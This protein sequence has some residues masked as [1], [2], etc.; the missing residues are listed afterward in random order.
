MK[1]DLQKFAKDTTLKMDVAFGSSI[2]TLGASTVKDYTF[3]TANSISM[4]NT[5]QI[6]F[7][8]GG[9]GAELAMTVGAAKSHDKPASNALFA[10]G[11]S[12]DSDSVSVGGS[13]A[14]KYDELHI[15]KDISTFGF[16]INNTNVNEIDFGGNKAKVS[17]NS[18]AEV[19]SLS[20]TGADSIGAQALYLTNTKEITLKADKNSTVGSKKYF[21]VGNTVGSAVMS[22]GTSI[23]SFNITG[24]ANSD[25]KF[26]VISG[27]KAAVLN[28]GSGTTNAKVSFAGAASLT[29]ALDSVKGVSF[30]VDK[31]NATL[32][33]DNISKSEL[34]ITSAVKGA[35][36]DVKKADD[37]SSILITATSDATLGFSGKGVETLSVGYLTNASIAVNN[38]LLATGDDS[39]DA[40]VVEIGTLSLQSVKGAFTDKALVLGVG[41]SSINIFSDDS[42]STIKNVAGVSIK[43]N[44]DTYNA[45]IVGGGS[46]AKSQ[47]L[48]LKEFDAFVGTEDNNILDLGDVDDKHVVY[49]NN[50]IGG[51]SWGEWAIYNNITQVKT[52][53]AG[54]TLLVSDMPTKATSLYGAGADD[55]IF[56]GNGGTASVSLVDTL[57]SAQGKRGWFGSSDYSGHDVVI[58]RDT[59]NKATNNFDYADE[60]ASDQEAD[61]LALM[62]G[63]GYINFDS[64][65]QAATESVNFSIGSDS[66]N[67]MEFRNIGNAN[68]STNSHDFFYTYD[69]GATT[70]KGRVDL[71]NAMVRGT[72]AY[73]SEIEFY[74]GQGDTILTL[75]AT[76]SKQKLNY[77]GGGVM[78]NILSIDASNAGEGNVINGE[79]NNS[80][81][82]TAATRYATTVCGGFGGNYSDTGEDTLIGGKNT[83]F[84]VGA[85]MGDDEIMNVDSGDTIV[86]LG[87]KW[88]DV[89]DFGTSSTDRITVTFNAASGGSRIRMNTDSSTTFQK[90]TDLT[91]EFDDC[92]WKWDGSNW[93]QTT[94]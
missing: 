7:A 16:N 22:G 53:S 27:E 34:S 76:D 36:I 86:F 93:T 21:T 31:A 2:V 79:N 26:N 40:N 13:G 85:N 54:K 87:S 88:A 39:D 28:L 73:D 67:Y 50:S 47:N 35:N 55:S 30:N 77:Q 46:L 33:F 63:A 5:S 72:M 78:M 3:N 64:A 71:T 45:L 66:L 49:L 12:S 91:C 38:W 56:S 58:I 9:D 48:D 94:K 52:S 89:T 4:S 23:S 70:F 57:G 68:D 15:L 42:G 74:L 92:T 59:N 43:N 83:T 41:N 65:T 10:L 8:V 29:S 90:V 1:F 84:W 11:L 82:I 81:A 14:V 61:V 75:S 17:L 51:S 20:A 32:T 69:L 25:I 19:V 80:Q 37:D 62:H 24:S 18:A 44:N 6:G 60:V